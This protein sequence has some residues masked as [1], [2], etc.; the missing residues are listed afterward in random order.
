MLREGDRG[1]M[2]FYIFFVWTHLTPGYMGGQ[3]LL[4]ES[5]NIELFHPR[6][7]LS[8]LAGFFGNFAPKYPKIGKYRHF[9]E[10][11]F[12][13]NFSKNEYF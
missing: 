3:E 1:K 10:T 6:Y 12:F 8:N 13:N 9:L 2:K 11:H 4:T 7:R 5:K